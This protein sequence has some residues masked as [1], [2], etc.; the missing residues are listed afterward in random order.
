MLEFDQFPGVEHGEEYPNYSSFSYIE[1]PTS[2]GY[3]AGAPFYSF[4]NF[5]Y[6][7]KNKNN[8]LKGKWFLM[9]S[10]QHYHHFLKEMLAPFLYY[11]NNIDDSIKILWVEVPSFNATEHKMDVI[12]LEIKQL[13]SGFGVETFNREDISVSVDE[14]I[15]FAVGP[16]FL[17]I[18]NFIKNYIFGNTHY[19]HFPEA[20]KE[21]RKFFTP[22]MIEDETKPKKIFVSR[23]ESN[24]SL[25]KNNLQNDFGHRLRYENSN[26]L[27]ALED[28]YQEQGYT[29]LSLSGMSIF[30]QISYFYNAEKIAGSPGTNLCNLIF[31]KPDVTVNEIIH[32][33]EYYYPWHIEFDSVISP[34]YQSINVVGC[35]GYNDTINILKESGEK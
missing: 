8:H 1:T 19:Y 33:D 21:L 24:V 31:S 25:E 20:N 34:K 7:D 11:K 12:N 3:G 2:H 28:Y 9:P 14:L 17:G 22:F 29:I 35:S 4:K 10:G 16:R 30:E 15:T 23:K 6:N 5:Y 27:Q 26:F 13:L 32:F 18:P